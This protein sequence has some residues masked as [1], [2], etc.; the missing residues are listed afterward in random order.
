MTD[1]IIFD[2]DGTLLNTLEDL[3]LSTNHA[4]K[5]FNYPERTLEEIRNFVGNGVAKL[6]ERAIPN[7]RCNPDFEACLECFKSHYSQT[8][9]AHTA[10]YA[11]IIDM[12]LKL[13]E[14]GYKIAV[15]SNKFDKAVKDLCKLYFD[16]LVPV[17]IGEG[18]NTRPKPYPD[19]V[20]KAVLELNSTIS[21]AIYSGDSDVDVE[22]AHNAGLKCIGV[23]WGFRSVNVLKNAGADYIINTPDKIIEILDNLNS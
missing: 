1:T 21:N 6:I 17:A 15:V 11:G 10:P 14:K 5:S 23:T 9:K 12:L 2:L 16:T 8:L 19:G 18:K 3:M 13:Q 22:T 4:L 7:G 20:F